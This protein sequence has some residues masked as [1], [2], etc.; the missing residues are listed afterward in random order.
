MPLGIVPELTYHEKT[1]RLV[2][3]DQ[4]VL[5]TDGITESHN[6][7]GEMFGLARLDQVLEN[8]AIGASD[9]LESVLAALKEFTGRQ[10]I[11]DDRTLLVAKI[12]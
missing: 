4:L 11:H 1:Y 7:H 2:P 6:E 8:C 10:A 9:L 3:G 5:Y 12:K